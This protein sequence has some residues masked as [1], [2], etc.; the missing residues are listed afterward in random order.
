VST[1]YRVAS[2]HPEETHTGATF[3]PGEEAVGFDPENSED[4][5]KL[6][7]GLFV[8]IQEKAPRP[9]SKEAVAKAEELG[10]DLE[11]VAGT[12]KDGAVTVADVERTHQNQEELS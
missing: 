8:A 11:E 1:R 3:A 9:P 5:R 7:E 6:E 10:I 4:A 12:G 2:S